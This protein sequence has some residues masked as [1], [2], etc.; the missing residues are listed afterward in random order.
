MKTQ[1]TLI[2][3]FL[4]TCCFAQKKNVYF[5]KNDGKQVDVRDSADFIRVVQEP[6]SGSVLYNVFDFYQN[7]SKKMVG[8]SSTIDPQKL[9]GPCISFYPNGK[10]KALTSYKK[11]A[12]LGAEY[13]F[14]NSGKIYM[15]KEYLDG[16]KPGTNFKDDYLIKENY[17]SVG[18]VLVQNGNGYLKAFNNDFDDVSEEGSVKEGRRDGQWKGNSK[19]Q[20]IT[21]TE[22][23]DKGVLVKGI[24][25][26]K[27]GK[28][29]VYSLS[30][31]NIPQFKGG[32]EAF[33]QYI[34][35][36]IHY[37]AEER[38]RNIQGRT[39]IGFVID[40]TGHIHDLKIVKSVSPGIDEEALRAMKNCPPWVAGTQ[41]GRP[42]RVSFSVPISF[43]LANN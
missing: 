9:E 37:P 15:V 40:E 20:E 11:G 23:Y 32:I 17:D 30:R 39:V 16:D 7:N 42:A 24:S 41:F 25:L 22:T 10:R 12:K 8:K 43:T 28:S 3:L 29:A 31:E 21:F 36:T 18:T 2:T 26:D 1:L 34:G 5:L 4:Y 19:I 14:Y 33:Y 6:D 38:D 27:D 35:R 13:E